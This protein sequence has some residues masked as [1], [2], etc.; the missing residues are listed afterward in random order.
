MPELFRPEITPEVAN[1]INGAFNE[2]IAANL[3]TRALDSTKKITAEE[4]GSASDAD[5][6][7]ILLKHGRQPFNPRIIAGE[8]AG[9]DEG[10]PMSEVNAGI[11]D[12]YQEVVSLYEA[13]GVDGTKAIDA[14]SRIIGH[15]EGYITGYS[16]DIGRLTERFIWLDPKLVAPTRWHDKIWVPQEDEHDDLWTDYYLKGSDAV[17]MVQYSADHIR[18]M[19]IGMH[20]GTIDPIETYVYVMMQEAATVESYKGAERLM[21]ARLGKVPRVIMKDEAPHA[22]EYESVIKAIAQVAPDP[23]VVALAKEFANFQMPGKEGIRNFSKMEATAAIAGVLDGVITLDLMRGFVDRLGIADM[24]VTSDEAK[25]AQDWLLDPNGS[26][27]DTAYK[28]AQEYWTAKRQ[29]AIDRAQNNGTLLP[30]IIGVTVQTDRR[31]EGGLLF[32]AV[33]APV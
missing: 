2:A 27:G 1:T 19:Q 32:P 17:D 13:N 30:A 24:E 11:R 22:R 9:V 18:H 6:E 8:I 23:V 31:R 10:Q 5:F 4:I 25:Q 29:K 7:T 14:T 12:A 33:P 16:R 15:T 3:N 20:V 26:L 28:E 21:G